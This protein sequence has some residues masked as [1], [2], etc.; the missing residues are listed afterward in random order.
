MSS[1]CP[2]FRRNRYPRPDPP[3]LQ[4]DVRPLPD[5]RLPVRNHDPNATHHSLHPLGR[6]SRHHLHLPSR[7][8]HH[9]SHS[10][11]NSAVHHHAA[12]RHLRRATEHRGQ[13]WHANV[14][15]HVDSSCDFD[16]R[17]LDHF[18]PVLLLREPKGYQEGQEDGIEEG[19]GS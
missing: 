8:L 15:V 16:P 11:R 2:P 9:R 1:S 7:A 18:G 10:H 19:L 12:R 13:D 6:P 3:R 17:F 5:R 4:L 14:C